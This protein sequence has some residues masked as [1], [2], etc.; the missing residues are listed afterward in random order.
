MAELS[1][2]ALLL[3][4]GAMLGVL[5]FA[6]TLLVAT[7]LASAS[8]LV[9]PRA[10]LAGGDEPSR[11][12]EGAH[13]EFGSSWMGEFGLP[14]IA[15][16]GFATVIVAALVVVPLR[17]DWALFVPSFAAAYL[18][19]ALRYL[20]GGGEAPPAYGATILT[21]SA[22]G[23]FGSGALVA[24]AVT[25]GT[26][27][28]EAAPTTAVAATPSLSPS[29]TRTVSSPTIVVTTSAPPPATA[30]RATAG[31]TAPTRFSLTLAKLGTGS[32]IVATDGLSCLADCPKTST[33][34]P[35]NTPLTLKAS[36]TRGSEFAAWS[37]DCRGTLPS[38]DLVMT[39]ARTATAEFRFL[40]APGFGASLCSENVPAQA[41]PGQVVQIVICYQNTGSQSWIV[42]TPSQVDLGMCCPLNTPSQ[43]A[44]WV[45][46]PADSS[47]YATQPST[48]VGPQQL[49]RFVFSIQPPRGTA[50]G[51]YT[52]AG[53]PVLHSN[54]AP[55]AAPTFV[56]TVRVPVQ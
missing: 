19:S 20:R 21:L 4:A 53:A 36:P 48:I 34:Y 46:K 39:G 22:L 16:V 26:P 15:F 50:A 41:A 18:V 9:A 1:N 38:C 2:T 3:L 14:L 44:L 37:D 7:Q 17:F 42:S 13:A 45:V 43:Y 49:V 5:A 24:W 40:G 8:D 35:A 55:V 27:T 47:T 29:P 30:T 54:G 31:P 23:L 56:Q 52:F 11:P 25:G 51:D 6:L 28:P 32:G 33:T 10:L 12:R